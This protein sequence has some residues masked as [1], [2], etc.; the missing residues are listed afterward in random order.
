[1]K[2]MENPSKINTEVSA[3]PENESEARVLPENENE[4]RA[5]RK[6]VV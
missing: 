5:D 2:D 4:A 6:S 3:L 1:M